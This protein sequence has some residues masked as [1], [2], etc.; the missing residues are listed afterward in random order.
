MI[1]L[2]IAKFCFYLGVEIIGVNF[3]SIQIDLVVMKIEQNYQSLRSFIVLIN[4]D[5][6]ETMT[7]Y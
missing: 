4:H 1:F 2:F 6:A 7:F 3:D 5:V